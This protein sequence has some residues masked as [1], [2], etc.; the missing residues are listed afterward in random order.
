M[1]SERG[2]LG[3]GLLG[4]R[5]ALPVGYYSRALIIVPRFK[6]GAWKAT[7]V[8]RLPI[9]VPI[10]VGG[11]V[12]MPHFVEVRPRETRRSGESDRVIED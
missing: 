9:G 2:E 4:V 12:Q 7:V 8:E 6:G 3:L 1:S 10:V 5:V 11:G